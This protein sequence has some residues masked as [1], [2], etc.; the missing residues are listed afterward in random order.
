MFQKFFDPNN[1]LFRPMVYVADVL[2]L[3]ALWIVCSLP[4]FTVG[5]ATTAL[6]DSVVHCV[7]GQE[8]A[9]YGRFFRTFKQNFKKSTILTFLVM[10]VGLLL[11]ESCHIL[12]QVANAGNKTSATLY[13]AA[14]LLLLLPV[15]ML[16]YLFPVLSRFENTL[17]GTLLNACKLAIAHLP[18][19]VLMALATVLSVWLTMQFWAPVLILPVLLTLFWS[20][21]LEKSFKPF[22]P[23]EEELPPEPED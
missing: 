16:C 12:L 2:G 4:I 20:L 11:W 3:S 23:H 13:I 7:R 21:F 6:Y 15:G 19:T 22:L 8:P 14:C 10:A 9:P 17:G 18:A 5:A 1:W